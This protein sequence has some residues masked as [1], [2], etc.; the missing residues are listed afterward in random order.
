[1]LDG[2]Q[3][4]QAIRQ[5]ILDANASRNA[6]QKD[7]SKRVT[8]TDDDAQQLLA[9][10]QVM[11]AADVT[12]LTAAAVIMPGTMLAPVTNCTVATSTGPASGTTVAKVITDGVGVLR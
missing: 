9:G 2:A 8:I 1:M 11:L 5:A 6:Q 12:Y 7:A 4:A 3:R 10:L